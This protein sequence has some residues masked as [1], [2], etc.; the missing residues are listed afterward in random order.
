MNPSSRFWRIGLVLVFALVSVL[1]G[2]S[3]QKATDDARKAA[4]A[5]RKPLRMIRD[6]YALFS[7]VAVD[8]ERNEVVLLDYSVIGLVAGN[9]CD[10]VLIHGPDVIRQSR[11]RHSSVTHRQPDHKR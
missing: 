4:V 8:A 6:Q 5:N 10:G 7:A 11:H 3:Q 9:C 2:S 1:P